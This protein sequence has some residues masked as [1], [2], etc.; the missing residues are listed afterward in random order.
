MSWNVLDISKYHTI[1]NY[2]TAATS[3]DGVIIRAGYRGY[4]SA[5]NLATDTKLSTHY[6][7]F[8]DKT[9]IGYYW[10]TTAIST[11]EAVEEANYLYNLISSYDV[12][13][14]IYINS[15]PSNAT[16]TGR[17]DN[18]DIEDRTTYL[19]ATCDR[20]VELGLKAGIL[21]TENWFNNYLDLQAIYDS[22]YSIWVQ[23]N[24]SSIEPVMAIYDAWQYDTA[25]SV[26]GCDTTVNL[27]YFYKNVA[28][29]EDEEPETSTDINNFTVSIPQSEYTYTGEVIQPILK[30]GSL[31]YGIDYLMD[32]V[33]NTE[34]G[35]AYAIASGIGNYT[36]VV[37]KTFEI[38]PLDLADT[39][40]TITVPQ[41]SY[42]YINKPIIPAAS[43]EG[44]EED[45]DYTLEFANNIEVGTASIIA[46][47][48][49]NYTGVL[50]GLF[51][52]IAE[53]ITDH[54][55]W[56]DQDEFVYT[57]KSN[58]PKVTVL[59]LEEGKDFR[60]TY[61]NTIE[62]GTASAV[63][64]GINNYGG[65]ITLHYEIIQAHISGRI[66]LKPTTYVYNGEECR[67]E[68][69]LS[70]INADAYTI[71]YENNINAGT[72]TVYVYGQG[73]YT[74]YIEK[75]FRIKPK[76]ITDYSLII[77]SSI[78]E[79]SF[80]GSYIIPEAHIEGLEKDVDYSISY[81]HNF[82]V[83][84]AHILAHGIGNYTK[85]IETSFRIKTTPIQNCTATFG[86]PSEIS[87][88]WILGSPFQLNIAD[89]QLKKDVDYKINSQTIYSATKFKVYSF[90]V[91]GIGNFYDIVTFRFRVVT[92][93]PDLG[94]LTEDDIKDITPLDLDEHGAIDIITGDEDNNEYNFGDETEG[95]ETDEAYY[96]FGDESEGANY[97]VDPENPDPESI[98]SG[99]Y[100]FNIFG[101]Y[102]GSKWEVGAEHELDNTPI[103]PNHCSKATD[104]FK[105]GLYF[106]YKP[107][108]VDDKIRLTK[109]ESALEKPVRNTGWIT[110]EDLKNLGKYKVGDC[111]IVDGTI[112]K[113]TSNEDLHIDMNQ[114][115]MYIRK[116]DESNKYPYAV[117]Y[118]KKLDI[119][120]YAPKSVLTI[121]EGYEE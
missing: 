31:K 51:Y 84:T 6:E 116:I 22:A 29:W 106:I 58:K 113:D 121:Y 38:V 95:G 94:S 78:N 56:L 88:Y 65:T 104:I 60:V 48:I 3:I 40:Y 99:M 91:Q 64:N 101:Y 2:D 119:I 81:Q 69:T 59:G 20:L 110:I 17:A 16:M 36:G 67:P 42:T 55:A 76:S 47:G 75:S 62:V 44:L 79:Y 1:S 63:I 49:G 54:D 8:Q 45:V 93:E 73:N 14:P 9:K 96:D 10:T 120:G 103:Y 4:G 11:N 83:G 111:V 34:V 33:N 19:L 72:A 100:D 7:G 18:L 82:K 30:V 85:Y 98:A 77:D 70:K 105:S 107:Q 74:G 80:N 53:T 41:T 89:Y 13:F 37:Y 26:E 52:I 115:I 21:A 68:V 112:Y 90:E 39:G 23:N 12:D 25:A 87:N 32:Y 35:L 24:D 114:E 28:G 46:S 66:T 27:S 61:Q 71:E 118:G 57:G 92:K 86:T 50:T 108:I 5:G 15:A 117:A 43:I 97:P 109:L 102:T